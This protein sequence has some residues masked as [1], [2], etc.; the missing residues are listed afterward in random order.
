LDQIKLCNNFPTDGHCQ[1][2]LTGLLIGPGFEAFLQLCS[3]SCGAPRGCSAGDHFFICYI[4][5][6]PN[7]ISDDYVIQKRCV[8]GPEPVPELIVVML[9]HSAGLQDALL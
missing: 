6:N 3:I 4:Q 8:N 1:L 2:T 7:I 5:S 9:V